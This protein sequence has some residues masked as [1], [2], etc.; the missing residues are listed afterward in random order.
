M[1]KQLIFEIY[2]YVIGAL[3]TGIPCIIA[4]IR[5]YRQGKHAKTASEQA[6]AKSDLKAKAAELVGTIEVAYKGI[7]SALKA[8]GQ[9]AGTLKKESVMAK[10]QS[11]AIQCGY[12]DNYD[13]QEMSDYVEEI[14]KLT[15]TVNAK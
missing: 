2:K 14:V 3:C 10:L 11:Y 12:G 4:M 5:S 7:D 13:E 9:T 1:D 8:N 6:I 15:K